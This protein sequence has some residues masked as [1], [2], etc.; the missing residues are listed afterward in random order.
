MILMI[1]NSLI[2][3]S[4]PKCIEQ[5]DKQHSSGNI[6]SDLLPWDITESKQAKKTAIRQHI[7][8]LEIPLNGSLDTRKI[9]KIFQK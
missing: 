1:A 4:F 8:F 2:K 6:H 3:Q 9:E 7:Y 5:K